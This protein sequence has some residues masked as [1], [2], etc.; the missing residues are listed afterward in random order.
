MVN[1]HHHTASAIG[2]FSQTTQQNHAI[3]AE[4]VGT[5]EARSEGRTKE[6]YGSDNDYA[7]A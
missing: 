5:N 4:K 1:A 7:S 2:N 6:I 3:V